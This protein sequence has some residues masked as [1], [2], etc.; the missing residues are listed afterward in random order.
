MVVVVLSLCVLITTVLLFNA[1]RVP[2]KPE[3][4]VTENS[5]EVFVRMDSFLLLAEKQLPENLQDSWDK[6]YQK[7]PIDSSIL[8]W[9]K[10]KR[11]DIAALFAQKLAE[12][13]KTGESWN[14]AGQR[15][16]ASAAFVKDATE[17]PLLF[18]CAVRCF[19][20][21]IA[22]SPNNTDAKINL[23][24][25]FVEGSSDPMRGITLL[26]EI[27]RT[28]SNNVKLQMNFGYFSIRSGQ[29][30][31]AIRRFKKVIQLDSNYVEGYLQLA[32]AQEASGKIE[33]C[34]SS[35]ET[36][37]KKT[38]DEIMR[39]SIREYVDRLKKNKK[40]GQPDK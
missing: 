28:D 17:L 7:L 2:P 6:K 27:E 14:F 33:E 34:I 24:I 21:A 37:C 23:A 31:R 38:D 32:Q 16:Y 13:Q 20:N 29:W 22:K 25:C 15:F 26:R 35:L 3:K 12:Q 30:D 1:N 39:S 8:F 10:Q 11:P 5:I 9:D 18:A 40:T 4:V 36:F 19:E